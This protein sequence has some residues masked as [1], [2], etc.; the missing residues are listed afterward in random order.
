MSHTQIPQKLIDDLA[1]DV[2]VPR[3]HVA[4]VL[5]RLG[6][7]KAAAQITDVAGEQGLQSLCVDSVRLAVR[8]GKATLVV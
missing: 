5:T 6:L 7:D 1:K 2:G 4:K 8:F 3:D